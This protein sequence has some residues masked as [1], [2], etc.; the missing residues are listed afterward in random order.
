MIPFP[1][2]FPTATAKLFLC[3]CYSHF[4]FHCHFPM[5]SL[6]SIDHSHTKVVVVGKVST[7]EGENL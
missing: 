7:T 1:L 2:H 5:C 3:C 4:L 6:N